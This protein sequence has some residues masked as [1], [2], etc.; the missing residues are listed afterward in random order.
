MTT[1]STLTP[2]MRQYMQ[3]KKELSEDTILLFRMGDFYELFF[4]DARRGAQLMDIVLTQRAG[5]PM[6]GVPY[7]AAQSYVAR[8]LEQGVKVALAEQMEDPKLAKGLVKREVIQ[9]ITPGTVLDDQVLHAASSHFLV[10]IATARDRYGLALLDFSTG[11][12]RVTELQGRPALETEL[13][14]L[15]P[16]ECLITEALQA[17][18]RQSGQTPDCPSV[19]AWTPLEDWIFD[20]AVAGER[21]CR[22]FDV[23]SLDGFG[24][25]GMELAIGAAGAV[26][27]YAQN[28]L[29]RDAGHI[30]AL[31]VYQTDDGMILDR[32]SQRNLE[33]VEP[34]FAE[35]RGSTLISVLDRTV[36]PMGARLLREWVLRPLCRL[37]PIRERQEAVAIFAGEPMLLGELRE[38]LG[39][40]KD[41]ERT[42]V[43]ITVGSANARDLVVLQRGLAQVPGLRAIVDLA[44]A[45]L[46]QRLGADLVELPELTDLIGRAIVDEP[47]LTIREGGII[48]A[49]FHAGLDEL[50][51]AATEGKNWIAGYQSKEQERTGIRSLKVRYNKVF[52]YYIEVTKAN[53]EMVPEDYLRKQTLVGAERFITP[54]LKEIEDKILG[55]EEK[56]KALEY[57]LF[58]EIREAVVRSTAVIQRVA[59]AIAAVDALASLGDVAC[60]QGYCRPEVVEETV[61]N[62]VEG[63]HPVLDARLQ[64]EPFV[65]NDTLLDTT[66]NQL[67][68]ITGPNMAGKSTYIRQV[69]LLTLMA[70]MG[71]FLPARSARIGLVDR[72]FTRVGAAD[73]ISRGQSTFM[74]EM[75]ETANILNNATPR[76]LIILDE[77]GR[78]TSTFDGLSLAWAVAEYLHDEPRVKA[79]C[80]F[81]THY[82]ELTELSLT[83][84][85]VKN[86]NVAVKEYGDKIV[87]L[88]KIMPGGTDKSYGIH[89]AR[90]AG[91]PRQVIRRAGE[92]LTNLECDEL[93]EDSKPKLARSSRGGPDPNYR[94]RRGKDAGA[95]Q[96]MLFEF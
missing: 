36:T 94:R 66:E 4:D 43:R 15:R 78:G 74:V 45:P 40:V 25:R 33:L 10:A 89:V 92:V 64:D 87:F 29:R 69:A 3:A 84:N 5:V 48:R 65:P 72:I 70:Q 1:T 39:A 77:I 55:S 34:I 54:E 11:D 67:A 24:C 88:R 60:R 62:I 44:P 68:V 37:E 35:A 13:Q 52:G 53:L 49:G 31:T 79:R 61:L 76:S 14:R 20:P 80:L 18:W 56:S 17:Q 9:V 96:Q 86:Y 2:A 26:L 46:L 23:A 95:G 73:D 30:T 27:C 6:C 93:G 81:A 50:R 12:F 21:L 42:V 22:H 82:H 83:L 47:P 90:L 57:E 75:V 16:A 91:L 63:R 58:Q 7:H 85:G 8:M 28:N 59:R 32:I 71:S 38:A 41:I 51:R 19:L